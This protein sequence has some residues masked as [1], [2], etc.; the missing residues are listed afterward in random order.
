LNPAFPNDILR[1]NFSGVKVTKVD[2]K[3]IKF[4]LEKP[5]AF[6]VSNFLTGIC[7]KHILKDVNPADILQSDFNKT[8]W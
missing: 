4:T 3:N 5:N 6:F 8:Y 2:D 1:T 7:L